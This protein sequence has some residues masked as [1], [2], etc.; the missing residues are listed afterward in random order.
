MWKHLLWDK[1]TQLSLSPSLSAVTKRINEKI[2]WNCG[3]I[4]TWLSSR[5]GA[6]WSCN[7]SLR[8]LIGLSTL[9]HM[10]DCACACDKGS[11]CHM[12]L[13][14]TTVRYRHPYSRIGLEDVHLMR[15]KKKDFLSVLLPRIAFSVSQF[16]KYL[17][18]FFMWRS[19]VHVLTLDFFE[20]QFSW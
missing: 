12:G 17:A 6:S 15:C 1:G 16:C 9:S 14:A 20:R 11:K 7:V 4:H 5:V 3:K 18:D 10:F 19:S 13:V 2:V 8:R